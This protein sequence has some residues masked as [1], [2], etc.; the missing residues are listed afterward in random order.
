MHFLICAVL[1]ALAMW[2]GRIKLRNGEAFVWCVALV[3]VYGITMEVGQTALTGGDR[4]FS[5]WDMMA[6]AAGAGTFAALYGLIEGGWDRG[7]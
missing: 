1:A 4:T 2:T 7:R 6:N 5:L 3:T